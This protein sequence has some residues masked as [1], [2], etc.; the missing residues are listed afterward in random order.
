MSP[1]EHGRSYRKAVTDESRSTQ[2]DTIGD[3]YG[4]CNYL[5]YLCKSI[6]ISYRHSHGVYIMRDIYTGLLLLIIIL[7]I[8]HN[9]LL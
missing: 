9:S 7:S 6:D 2:L 1:S 4:Q 5:D 3:A 8:A